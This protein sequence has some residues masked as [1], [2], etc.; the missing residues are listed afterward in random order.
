MSNTT[1]KDKSVTFV[2]AYGNG[3]LHKVMKGFLETPTYNPTLD[4]DVYKNFHPHAYH[5]DVDEVYVNFTN[6]SGRLS[7]VPNG[8]SVVHGGLQMWLIQFLVKEWQEAFFDLPW[9]DA[10]NTHSKVISGMLGQEANVARYKE[11]HEL[12]YLPVRIKSLPEGTIVPYQ[13][14]TTTI[15]NTH[16]R[17]PWLPN[18]LETAFSTDNWGISTSLTTSVE[19]MKVAR[20][21]FAL[22]GKP[23][24]F[25]MFMIHDF[26][27]RGM[28]GRQAAGMSGLG[29]LMSGSAGTDTIPAV[30]NAMKYYGADIDSELIGASVNATEHSVTCSWIEEGEETFVEYLINE[31]AKEGIL[32]F[33]SDTWDFWNFVTATLPKLKDK[34]MARDGKF[35][36]RP[37]SGCPVKILTGYKVAP[38][39]VKRMCDAFDD[40]YEAVV[41][42]GAIRL[43]DVEDYYNGRDFTLG[44]EVM[45][46]EAKGLIETLWDIFGGTYTTVERKAAGG[47]T[48]EHYKMLDEHIGAI[49]GD[50]I[51]LE[52]QRDIYQRLMDKGF[53]PEPVLGVGSYSFQYVTRDTHGSA[54][55]AT[56]VVKKGEDLAIAKDPKTDTSKKSAKGLLMIDRDAD[57]NIF[58]KDQCTREEEQQGML[59]VVYEDGKL[60][61]VTTLEEIRALISSQI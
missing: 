4:Q 7:N 45:E 44:A 35:V 57:G 58:M 16:K 3:N 38:P 13:V 31:P 40:G 9:E 18:K 59:R 47:V 19:Y 27:M 36:I 55:K 61:N 5:P 29:H 14:A 42:D 46:C 37:D 33:V 20:E 26:S 6:R 48:T 41:V 49:Y 17:F 11:L 10:I 2:E 22:T 39:S 56:N 21:F 52:R 8:T 25:I 50:S 15:V 24:D 1:R 60:F 34:L 32:S 53:C 23:M 51:T 12:G 43:I 30:I 28:F 54:V